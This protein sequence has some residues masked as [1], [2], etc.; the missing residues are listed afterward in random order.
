MPRA[1]PS[2][3]DVV[4]AQAVSRVMSLSHYL[5]VDRISARCLLFYVSAGTLRL[6][7]VEREVRVQAGQMIVWRSLLAPVELRC[8]STLL[9]GTCV[10]MDHDLEDPD[11]L[12][13]PISSHTISLYLDDPMVHRCAEQRMAQLRDIASIAPARLEDFTRNAVEEIM[14][15][16][17]ACGANPDIEPRVRRA[18][19][20]IRQRRRQRFQAEDLARRVGVSQ[21]RLCTLFRNVIGKSPQQ[22]HESLRLQVAR[23]L[24]RSSSRSVKE[25]AAIIGY[26]SA[27]YFSARFKLFVGMSP[28]EYRAAARRP[29]EMLRSA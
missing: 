14:L 21:S 13:E 15:W 28:S 25:I 19:R 5:A 29:A 18:M 22:Y 4:P 10:L 17:K 24:L 26:E 12:L 16:I 1:L 11:W 20:L 3:S 27:F 9:D 7:S 2:S 6:S 23:R 8:E